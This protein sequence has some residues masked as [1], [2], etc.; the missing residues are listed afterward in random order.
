M[1]IKID[2]GKCT[3]CQDCEAACSM[4]HY[5]NEV[6]PKKSRIRVFEDEEEQRFFPVICRANYH[7]R[8]HFQ[9]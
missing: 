2:H 5:E 4:K 7:C 9:I 8:M 3:G 6:N 1:R